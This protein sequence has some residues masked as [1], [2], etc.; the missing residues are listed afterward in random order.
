MHTCSLVPNVLKQQI[1]LKK[2]QTLP[3]YL[4]SFPV[5]VYLRSKF[6]RR[7]PCPIH[8]VL[9]SQNRVCLVLSL[10][11]SGSLKLLTVSLQLDFVVEYIIVAVVRSSRLKYCY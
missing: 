5:P 3:V 7:N 6:S 1:P 9:G 10:G 11:I 2:I 4:A 8:Q